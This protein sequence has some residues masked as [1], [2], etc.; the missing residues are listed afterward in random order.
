MQ[1]KAPETT[2]PV[3]VE[4]DF[5]AYRVADPEEFGRNML[6]LMEEGSK[7]L[8]GFLERTNGPILILC[9]ET[10]DMWPSTE[11]TDVVL[12]RTVK[13]RFPHPVRRLTFADAGHLITLPYLPVRTSGLHPLGGRFAYGGTQAGT[14]AARVAAWREMLAFLTTAVGTR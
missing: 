7:V 5:G 2:K 11:L 6:K 1:K 13:A 4:I 12:E 14:A 10:D 8:S 9:G 3:P